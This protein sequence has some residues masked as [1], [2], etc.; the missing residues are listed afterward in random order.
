MPAY[1]AALLFE[2]IAIIWLSHNLIA[3]RKMK[4]PVDGKAHEEAQAVLNRAITNAQQIV[5]K[6][7]AE[8]VAIVSNSKQEAQDLRSSFESESDAFR[9]QLEES[10]VT[11]A[12]QAMEEFN[13]YLSDLRSQ[14][15]QAQH[16]IDTTI[17]E[18]TK[19]M[20]ESLYNNLDVYF[21]KV[22]ADAIKAIDQETQATKKE[23][24]TYKTSQLKV[25]D[26]N[27][28]AILEQTTSL[29]IKNKL[30]LQDH[31]DLIRESL[32]QA[33]ADGFLK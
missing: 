29:V 11:E 23:L 15:G 30:T 7:Q 13:Y 14:S 31:S 18:K 20:I 5:K 1:I 25:I 4:M 24:E 19:E 26:E 17:S 10:F 32:D 9:S 16:L 27:I 33:K 21:K 3:S 6:A 22:Q 2:F 8:A 28:I 12:K